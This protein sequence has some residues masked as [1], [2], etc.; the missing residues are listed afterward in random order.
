MVQGQTRAMP[1]GRVQRIDILKEN[2]IIP[3]SV[4]LLSKEKHA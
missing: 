2:I 4:C 3:I 1:L